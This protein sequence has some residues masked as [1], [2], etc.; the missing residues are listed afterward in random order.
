MQ[1]TPGD[2]ND[3]FWL[4]HV[5]FLMGQYLRAQRLLTEPMPRPRQPG[6]KD[7]GKGKEELLKPIIVDSLPCR[8]LAAQCLIGQEK[9]E[10]ALEMIGETNPFR[11]ESIAEVG[12]LDGIRLHSTMCFLRGILYLRLSS[13]ALAKESFIEALVID[14]KNYDAFREIVEGQMMTAA[15][16]E[17]TAHL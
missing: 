8:S 6:D 9:Y 4:A 5:Y 7:K 10:E 15:E 3:A 2:T 11:K 13:M 14:V 1:L 17:F 12:P 16:G